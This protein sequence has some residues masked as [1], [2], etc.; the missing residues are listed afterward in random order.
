MA[1]P[2][3]RLVAAVHAGWRGVAAGVL[4]EAVCIFPEPGRV[5]A[6]IGPAVG[7]DHYE[8]AEDV[9]AAVGSASGAGAI[10]ARGGAR[11]HL[12]LA[13]TVARILGELGVG[14]VERSE[15]CTACQE[16][17]YFSYRRDGPTGRQALVAARL[18]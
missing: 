16:A 1:D 9:V 6:A 8:V 14:S 5:L 3:T 7:P 10:T 17:R 15:D 18:A 11:P 2:V 12:D 4:T 13:G